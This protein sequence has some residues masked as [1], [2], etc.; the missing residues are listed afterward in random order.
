[1]GPHEEDAAVAYRPS[2]LIAD[3]DHFIQSMLALRLKAHF[4]VLPGAFTASE[5]VDLATEH[6]PDLAIVDVSMPGGGA[7]AAVPGIAA[8]SP[9]TRVVVLSGDE[10]PQSVVELLQAGAVAYLRKGSEDTDLGPRLFEVLQ[11]D[12]G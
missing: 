8:A 11:V 6:H 10:E 1:M 4:D 7:K 3:D 5:A 2:V 9:R 12:A